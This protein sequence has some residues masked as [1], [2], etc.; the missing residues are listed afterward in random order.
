MPDKSSVDH[1]ELI[2]GV[3]DKSSISHRALIYGVPEKLA[4]ILSIEMLRLA[5]ESIQ[6]EFPPSP[7]PGDWEPPGFRQQL[8]MIVA[9]KHV[10][11]TRS[12][13]EQDRSAWKAFWKKWDEC[14]SPLTPAQQE[15]CLREEAQRE[16]LAK[17]QREDEMRTARNAFI[18]E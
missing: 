11:E 3:P 16:A 7:D 8:L 5:Q 18:K 10:T 9:L 1:R 17:Q 6:Q 15:Q 4:G 2:Y 12:V 14:H 13:D